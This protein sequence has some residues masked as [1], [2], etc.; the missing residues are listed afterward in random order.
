MPST[1]I[2][3]REAAVQPNVRKIRKENDEFEVE[4]IAGTTKNGFDKLNKP[5]DVIIINDTLWV[6]DLYN[7]QLKQQKL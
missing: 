6:E 5:A 2:R 1:I 3:D 7:H 4:T